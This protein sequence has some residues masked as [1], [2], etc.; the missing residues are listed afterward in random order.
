MK[1]QARIRYLTL[2][3]LTISALL[4]LV[5]GLSGC[6]APPGDDPDGTAPQ[7]CDPTILTAKPSHD[8]LVSAMIWPR[9]FEEA[10]EL[11]LDLDGDQ[12]VDNQ[13]GRIIHLFERNGAL[14]SEHIDRRVD[15]G[16]LLLVLRIYADD[17]QNDPD[18]LVQLQPAEL[19]DATPV[20]D[21][22]DEVRLTPGL[23]R[24]RFTCGAITDG[25]LVTLAAK[26]LQVLPSP[27]GIAENAWLGFH[28]LR[29]RGPVNSAELNDVTI[30]GAITGSDIER[31]FYAEIATHL[32]DKMAR[33]P[34]SAFTNSTGDFL[35]GN[36]AALQ[37][38]EL[39]RNVVPGQGACD[40]TAWP[41]VITATELR[42]N[43]LLH[44][45][46]RFDV[47]SDHD[48]DAELLGFGWHITAARV[49]V[50]P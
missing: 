13:G 21:G 4:I 26:K 41:P 5:L 1:I 48:G 42:C 14:I 12:L 9:S 7:A 11:G 36:C 8:F 15:A 10:E 34:D 38:V 33:D 30:A 39:C 32:T 40:D 16:E 50:L 47:D 37:D 28:N 3:A 25:L 20:F 35:D 43:A 27:I 29:I 22:Q 17:L 31:V 19:T 46:L 49:T 6:P 23:D 44:S 18:V 45:A 2:G 24:G